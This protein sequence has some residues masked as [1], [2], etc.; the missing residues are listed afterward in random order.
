MQE[1]EFNPYAAGAAASTVEA[2]VLSFELASR[3][4]RFVAQLIDAVLLVT[5]SWPFFQLFDWDVFGRSELTFIQNLLLGAISVAVYLI[6]NGYLLHKSGQT[7]GK[8][9]IRIRVVND[10]NTPAS[11]ATLVVYRYL[12]V[13][14]AS[15]IPLFRILALA[16]SLFIFGESRRCLHDHI[17]G[18][19][20]VKN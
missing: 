4:Q 12:P 14:V 10:D 17:A 11:F 1:N 15:A 18:T 2:P 6:L 13:Q 5:A 16:D 8:K 20:V 3:A 7:I 9:I 19:K